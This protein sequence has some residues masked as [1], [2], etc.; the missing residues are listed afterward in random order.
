[1]TD[2]RSYDFDRQV[3]VLRAEI[4]HTRPRLQAAKEMWEAAGKWI[5]RTH[6]MLREAGN[7]V[8]SGW[9]DRPGE[10]FVDRLWANCIY[11]FGSWGGLEGLSGGGPVSSMGQMLLDQP[12]DGGITASGVVDQ[13]AK[14]D[15]Q[16]VL[17]AFVAAGEISNVGRDAKNEPAAQQNLGK[18]L[19]EIAAQ[20]RLTGQAMLA[21]RGRAWDGPSGEVRSGLPAN[22]TAPRATGTGGPDQN[23][24]PTDPG[25]PEDPGEPSPQN[26]QNTP[27]ALEQATDALSALSQAAESAQQL[28]GNGS[29]VNMPDPNAIDPGD[30]ALPPYD[31]S[32]YP[33]LEDPLAAPGGS[34]MPTLA[35]GGGMPGPGGGAGGFGGMPSVADLNGSPGGAMSGIGSM[36]GIASAGTAGSAGSASGA[37]GMPPPMMPPNNGG[38]KN[39]AGGVKP[40]DAEHP[41]SSRQRGPKGG[42]T[43]GVTLLGR[44][45]GGGTRPATAQRRWDTGNDT[46]H[47]LD[48]ELWQVQETTDSH[49][50]P[51]NYRA[52]H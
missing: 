45:R 32:T 49:E 43:P 36:P 24:A 8:A 14:A 22:G 6:L 13:L 38:G 47:L 46:V 20:Y 28:L 35:G 16:L 5:D 1:M 21:A 25:T 51:A 31:G 9:L 44:S 19:N 18:K 33:G 17:G 50:R 48:D 30:W 39:P 7:E 27:S 40:G 41:G 26:P 10:E 37:G 15:A 11:S 34:G 23:G 29:S 42:V 12:A 2:Y 52:G 3:R 4:A